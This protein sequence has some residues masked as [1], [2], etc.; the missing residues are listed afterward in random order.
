MMA[1]LVPQE[2]VSIRPEAIRKVLVISSFKDTDPLKNMLSGSL[3]AVKENWENQ[4]DLTHVWVSTVDEF[5]AALNA[6]DGAIL[7]FDGHGVPNSETP[8]SKIAIADHQLDVWSLRG[9]VKCPPI[10]ILSACD[11]QGVDASSHA[12]VGNGFIALGAQTVV[13]TFLPVHGARSAMFIAR[14]MHR[15]AEYVPAAIRAFKRSITWIDV[16][17]GMLRMLLAT[18]VIVALVGKPD[19]EEFKELQGAANN[20]IN[21]RNSDWFNKLID[22]VANFRKVDRATAERL[23]QD[24]V[25]RSDAIRY[26][27]LGNPENIL[28]SDDTI[29]DGV[30]EAYAMNGSADQSAGTYTLTYNR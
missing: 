15:I 28:I 6:F 8:I 13:G 17:S 26:T 23:V 11:T 21:S 2:P 4:I 12:T 22:R 20:E 3:E 27:Q 7:I 18:E 16:V 24:V 5:V 29:L 30:L 14:L 9:R 19:T 10:V 25:A 1:Q